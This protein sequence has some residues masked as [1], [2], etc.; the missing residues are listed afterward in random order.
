MTWDLPPER[1]ERLTHDDGLALYA[2]HKIQKLVNDIIDVGDIF[3]HA[4]L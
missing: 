2:T 1:E 4:R 3:H